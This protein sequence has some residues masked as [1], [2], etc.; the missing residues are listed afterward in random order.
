MEFGLPKCGMLIMKR[1]E[2]VKSEGISMPDGKMMKNIEEGGYK[3][4]GILE[5]DGVKHEEMKDQIKKEYI[6]R[7]RNILK[8]KLNGGKIISAI[9]SRAVSIARYGAGIIGWTTTKLEELDQR[10]RKL[11]T[12]YGAHHPKADVDTLYLQR[13]EGGRGLL[14]LKDCVQIEVHS[15]D[16]HLSTSKEKIL[17]EVSRSRIIENNKYGRS[18]EEIHKEHRE[19]SERKPLH[20]QFIKATEEVRSKRSWDWL[21]KGYLKKETESTIVA[22]QDQALC[23]RNL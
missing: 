23:T 14:G 11:M 22:A 18:K 5:A 19:K 16:K 13:G 10:T 9:N 21:K 15:L 3:Y 17:K 12:M 4:L 6:R 20:G 2:V 8:S 1:G 7:V